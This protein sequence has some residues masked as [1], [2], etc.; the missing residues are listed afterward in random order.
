MESMSAKTTTSLPPVTQ[1]EAVSN[2]YW[3]QLRKNQRW[4]RRLKIAG[5]AFLALIIV[6]GAVLLILYYKSDIFVT[7]SKAKPKRHK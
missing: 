7:S 5:L 3:A 2:N 6:A 1:L 4:F